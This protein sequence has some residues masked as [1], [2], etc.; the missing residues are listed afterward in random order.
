MRARSPA[1]HRPRWRSAW[2]CA[3]AQA[4]AAR[5][6]NAVVIGSDQ[7][8]E[9]DGERAGQARRPRPRGASNCARC[10]GAIV[11][12]HTAVAVVAARAASRSRRWSRPGALSR[13]ERRRD[14]TLPAARAALR[15]R[16]QRQ[17]RDAGHRAGR[18]DRVRRSDR[19][20]RAA[21][22]PHQRACCVRPGSIRW[23]RHDAHRAEPAW[24]RWCWCPTRWTSDRRSRGDSA[25]D[26]PLA[27]IQRAAALTHWVVE[28]AKTAR[29]FL[30]RVAAV[31]PLAAPLQALQ[32]V[33]LPRPRQGRRAAARDAELAALLQPAQARP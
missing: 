18:G 15:L 19:A 1:K 14:R 30:K 20:G 3:K 27:V 24:A 26:L 32:I 28:N 29:A 16:R 8:A 22:D 21:A 13:P 23:L 7:V 6:P 5:Q 12:F 9:L 4:V 10:A 33:E 17:V 11:R 2:R 31:A 25:L